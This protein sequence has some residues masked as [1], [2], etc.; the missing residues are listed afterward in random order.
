MIFIIF[1]QKKIVYSVIALFTALIATLFIVNLSKDF[2]YTN[3]AE[4]SLIGGESLTKE[5]I[6]IRQEMDK[7]Y[8]SKAKLGQKQT[9]QFVEGYLPKLQEY[10]KQAQVRRLQLKYDKYYGTYFKWWMI[11]ICNLI[12]VL[13]WF[14][15][16]LAL[17]ARKWFL[18]T[19]SEEDV[20]QMQTIIAILMN[21]TCD[22]LDILFWMERQSRVHKNAL[23]QA[24]HE[25]PS[26]PELALNRLKS[27]S[28]LIEFKTI[29][30]KLILTIHQISIQDAF[31][32]LITERDHILRIREITQV[33]AINKKRQVVSP[34]SMAPLIITALG[35]I[36]LPIGILG[37]Q[38]FT[39]AM[40]NM[41]F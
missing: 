4:L 32:D 7:I 10:D 41:G 24:Y 17:R 39:N 27:K 30:D 6:Q 28:N 19:E 14:G 8:L 12:S 18:R 40:S 22:T 2:I 1:I 33:S 34:L 25:Y 20:L 31:G 26:N 9:T 13:A 5:D 3:V 38:E 35:Y 11:V 23:L 21:T 37:F 36:L 15:P 29:V 16:E